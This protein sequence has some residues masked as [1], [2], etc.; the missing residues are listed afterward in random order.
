MLNRSSVIIGIVFS[1][2]LNRGIILINIIINWFT[3]CFP[4]H[5]CKIV[6]LFRPYLNPLCFWVFLSLIYISWCDVVWYNDIHKWDLFLSK[7]IFIWFGFFAKSR[8]S[9]LS[10]WIFIYFSFSNNLFCSGFYIATPW[11]FCC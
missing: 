4:P 5:F 10:A 3:N 2:L 1:P 11:F 7:N 8:H 6:S 9:F